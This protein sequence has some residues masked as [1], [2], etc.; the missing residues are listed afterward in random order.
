MKT[1]INNPTHQTNENDNSVQDE[2]FSFHT[3][4]WLRSFKGCEH[5]SDEEANEILNSLNSITYIFLFAAE[6]INN[7]AKIIPLLKPDNKK[8]A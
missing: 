8:A 7:K 1:D 4:D 2:T 5:Y 3:T 6:N